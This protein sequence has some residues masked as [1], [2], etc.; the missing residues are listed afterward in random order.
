[1]RSSA[2]R[3]A[4]PAYDELDADLA[5]A[6]LAWSVL[7]PGWFLPRAWRPEPGDDAADSDP[8]IPSRRAMVGH[9]LGRARDLPGP[10]EVVAFAGLVHDRLVAE[11]GPLE[12]PLAPAWRSG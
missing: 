2:N 6:T 7:T 8:R 3:A 9:R 10:S 5:L 11:W 4:V 1:M 12:L